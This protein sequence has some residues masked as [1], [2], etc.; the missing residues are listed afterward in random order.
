MGLINILRPMNVP[1]KLKTLK[2]GFCPWLQVTKLSK[3][4]GVK[5]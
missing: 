4:Y 3:Y 5:K 1:D 2:L